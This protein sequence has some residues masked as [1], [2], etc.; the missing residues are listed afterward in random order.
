MRKYN[1]AC[2]QITFGIIVLNGEPFIRYNLRSLYSWAHQI[3]VV[4]G[5][6]KTAKSVAKKNGHSIDGTLESIKGFIK[7]E[8]AEK[9]VLLV[10]A[11]DEG[12][13]DGFWPEKTEM[14]HAFARRATGN[15]LWQVDSDEFYLEQNMYEIIE[16]LEQGVGRII[17]PQHSFWGG[18]DYVNG[19]MGL[20]EFDRGISGSR[21]FA[22]GESYRYTEHRP[23]TVVDSE[24]KN[25]CFRGNI[26]AGMMA[27][28]GIYRYHY[29][30][31]FP[32]QVF[33]KVN[34]YSVPSEE[35]SRQGGGYS[36]S[37]A[38]WHESNYKH[39]TKPFYLHNIPGYRSWIKPFKGKHPEQV[40]KMM[41]DINEKRVVLELRKNDDIES[42]IRSKSYQLK[43]RFLDMFV[44]LNMT[45]IGYLLFRI[46]RKIKWQFRG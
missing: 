1:P 30:L 7:D 14:C 4:E 44:R 19:G 40:L 26:S 5:A 45:S 18:I 20:A 21:V 11:Q 42:L 28:K 29:C 10:T 32:S 6:C 12:F 33:T 15:Y 16:I 2:V 17:F 31:L 34:Y 3:I 9:K 38:A 35:K 36:S 27:K 37:I 24:G 22:W 23:P 13:E 41:S 43:T 25:V 8:D 39:I 46:A